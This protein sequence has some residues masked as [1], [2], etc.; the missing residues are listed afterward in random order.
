ML[1]PC[2]GSKLANIQ[3]HSQQCDYHDH[4]YGEHNRA[5]RNVVKCVIWPSLT[6]EM[7]HLVPHSDII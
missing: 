4:Q 7:I 5:F 3:Q 1:Y 6:D 2:G